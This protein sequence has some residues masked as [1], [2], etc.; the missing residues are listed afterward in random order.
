MKKIRIISVVGARPNFM[1]MAPILREL[2]KYENFDSRLVHTG[3]HYDESMSRVFFRDLN[4][5]DPDFNL[6]VGSG[7]H[8]IQTAECMKR[9]E[10]VCVQLKPRLVIVAGDVN[11][12]LACSLTA[13]KLEIPVAHIESGLRSF[14]RTMPEEINRIV[15]DSV[16]EFLFTTEESG[17]RNLRRE[18]IAEEKIHFVGNTM[19]DSLVDCQRLF[20]EAPVQGPLAGLNGAPYFLATIHRPSN[21]DDPAQLLEVLKILEA[22]SRLA[23]VFFVTHPRTYPRLQQINRADKLVELNGKTANI[24]RDYIYV[25]PPLP[26]M[27][28][29]QLMSKSKALL[30]DSGGIQEETTFLGIPCLTLRNNTERPSTVELGT[31]E[32]VGLDRDRIFSSLCRIMENSWKNAAI[33]PLW[34]GRAANRVVAVLRKAF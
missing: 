6:N 15:T 4:M 17:N 25:L 20:H 29:L 26:Y 30:T 16:S 14:D 32:I 11:S 28:F 33:P 5:P 31:N 2:A 27:E 21:V 12:T 19:M 9:F 13:T 23:P 10:E 7:S 34:D 18:G 24:Q 22:A 8:A 3:Q 1:K